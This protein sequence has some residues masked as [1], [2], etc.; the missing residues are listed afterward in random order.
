ML[1]ILQKKFLLS[2]EGSKNMLK[3]IIY[4][5]LLNIAFMMPMGVVFN[6]IRESL[7]I[8]MYHT[9][10]GYTTILYVVMAIITF[11]AIYFANNL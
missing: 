2:E 6:F 10:T 3:G 1:N 9:Q 5:A 8:Y 11:F 7:N 4:C